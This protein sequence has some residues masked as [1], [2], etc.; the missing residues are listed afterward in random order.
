MTFLATIM[1][2]YLAYLI[3]HK[4]GERKGTDKGYAR[5][6]QIFGGRL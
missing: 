5:A 6:K 1:V 3:G 2:I 4:R